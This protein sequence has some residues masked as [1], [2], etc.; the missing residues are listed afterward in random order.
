MTTHTVNEAYATVG[1]REGIDGVSRRVVV[2]TNR[3]LPD[4]AILEMSPRV[5]R[6]LARRLN[7]WA[8]LAESK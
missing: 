6:A 5:A 8:R 7:R 1:A 2:N 3:T 4:A